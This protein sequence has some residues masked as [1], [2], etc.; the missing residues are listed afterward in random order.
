MPAS[1]AAIGMPTVVVSVGG[2]DV[3]IFP[4][5]VLIVAISPWMETKV[6]WMSPKVVL[7]FAMF[8]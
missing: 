5:S 8:P 7:M 1:T 6:P 2:K 4:M 3:V